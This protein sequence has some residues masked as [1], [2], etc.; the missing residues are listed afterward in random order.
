MTLFLTS[1]LIPVSDSKFPEAVAHTPNQSPVINSPIDGETLTFEAG[2]GIEAK[3]HVGTT[4]SDG[5]FV[6]INNTPLPEGA[7]YEFV[8]QFE[9]LTD[10]S[11]T[12]ED[13]HPFVGTY[14]VTFT[15]VDEHGAASS[16]VTIEI[17]VVPPDYLDLQSAK[18]KVNK[19]HVKL[20]INVEG[21]V[22][23]TIQRPPYGFAALTSD[24][25][26]LLAVTTHAGILDSEDQTDPGDDTFHTHV[27]DVVSSDDCANGIKV[28]SASLES[29]GTLT[30]GSNKATVKKAPA[31]NFGEFDGT[32]ISFILTIEEG[33]ICVNPVDSIAK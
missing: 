17:V 30:V 25:N 7:F 2:Q 8:E 12:F 24:G 29:P 1:L 23:P 18:L 11:I 14:S 10:A 32:I 3:I 27:V 20:Q 6:N 33:T 15:A 21:S 31:G 9:G 16:P 28:V 19:H 4:D 26:G 5:D 13:G 22:A